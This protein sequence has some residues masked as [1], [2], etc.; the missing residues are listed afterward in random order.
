MKLK[1]YHYDAGDILARSEELSNEFYAGAPGSKVSWARWGPLSKAIA[2]ALKPRPP[3]VLVLSMPRSGSSW[4]GRILGG[5]DDALYLR[6]P[7]S[8]G[9]PAIRQRILFDPRDQPELERICRRLADRAFQGIPDFKDVVLYDPK[10]WSLAQRRHRRVVIK[11][12]NPKACPWYLERYRPRVVFLVRHPAA[13]AWS[14]QKHHWIGST[15]EAW[16]DW[17]RAQGECLYE[18]WKILKDYPASETVAFESLCDDPVGGF[19]RL[20]DFAGL[21]WTD[22][23]EELLS[24]DSGVS[25]RKIDEWQGVADPKAVEALR[26]GYFRS[27]SPWNR[28]EDDWRPR[29]SRYARIA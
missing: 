13:V 24:A 14:A 21:T 16:E 28:S 1:D 9:D 29:F 11:E 5:A 12:V 22:S 23:V 27:A 17:G 7:L 15:P 3:A 2:V 18:T 6:E 19:R 8:Q 25:P 26:R 4:V 20:Y 10:Q